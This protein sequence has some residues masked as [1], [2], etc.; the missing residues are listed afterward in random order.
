MKGKFKMKDLQ[1][2]PLKPE[3]AKDDELRQLRAE[4]DEK[5]LLIQRMENT[6]SWKVTKPLRMLRNLKIFECHW[7]Y[8][9]ASWKGKLLRFCAKTF[10][11]KRLILQSGL[12]DQEYYLK[13]NPDVAQGGVDPLRHF[14]RHGGFEGRK[15]N[16]FFDAAYYLQYNQDVNHKRIHPLIHYILYGEQEGRK[17]CAEFDPMYYLDTYSDVH[18]VGVSPLT[19]YLHYGQKEGRLTHAVVEE[20]NTDTY[21]Y[22][23]QKVRERLKIIPH[24][25]NHYTFIDLK[26]DVKSKKVG[27]HLHLFYVDMAD[28]FID[29]L[30]NISVKFTLFVS[31]TNKDDVE[32]ITKNFKEKVNNLEHIEVE[33][34]ENRGRDIA[35]LIITF[36][37]K[38][39]GF[40]YI[41]HVHTK[42]SPHYG[43]NNWGEHIINTL[44]G[45]QSI[46]N[47]N[48]NIL[49]ENG[50]IIFNEPNF[51]I[52]LYN[53]GWSGDKIFAKE[54]LEKYSHFD[55]NDFPAI[56]FPQGSMFWA[57]IDA[58][59]EFL[60]LPLSYKDFPTE[61][62][63]QDG[64]IAHA[65]E[66][67]MLI[68][69]SKCPGKAYCIYSDNNPE[70]FGYYE[71]QEDFSNY[72]RRYSYI[73]ILSYYL[74]QF[75]TNPVNDAWHG[76]GFTEWTKVAAAN[77]LFYTHY[78][79]HIPHKDLGYYH[80][81]TPDILKKQAEMMKK[82]G[83]YGQIFY[84]YWFT[85]RLILEKPAQILLD[86]KDI[87]MPFCFCW[88]NEN[89]TKKW[90]GSESETILEQ[91]YSQKDAAYFIRYL[92]PFF[93]DHRYI[94][95][96]LRPVL[97]IYRP[98]SFSNFLEYK[99]VWENECK[100]AGIPMPYLVS[101][102]TINVVSPQEYGMDAAVE[103]V[104]YDWT[105]G[106]CPEKK[107]KLTFFNTFNGTVL[108]YNDVA[109]Y[110]E[111]MD[112][113]KEFTWFRSVVPM[114]D[115][116]ARYNENA[117]IVHNS[118]PVRFQKWLNNIVEYTVKNL[119]NDKQFVIVNAWNEWAEGDHL[120]P[121]CK[122]GY[123]YLNSIGR[124]LS[125]NYRHEY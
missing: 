83:V 40:D 50:K 64:T 20:L 125:S 113:K 60:T 69:T 12:F 26:E 73:K 63:P 118:T 16:P 48:L 25:H 22:N 55:I 114:W 17:P 81:T 53:F 84:H 47:Q 87:D 5:N 67:I 121:D 71:E 109:K 124:V 122:Y 86:N 94:K 74:P 43:K 70:G 42:K 23:L 6:F 32:D 52:P 56:D 108:D 99:E 45:N 51:I 98:S 37:K 96:D 34:V 117:Y 111:D 27:I 41:C 33:V 24:F 102:L 13:H 54:L 93:K 106:N 18:E 29:K 39:L 75:D 28:Y 8:Q 112:V 4:L 95:I 1:Q 89:W 105:A 78:Q 58:M 46:V 91:T 31:T 123:A 9:D 76:K 62:L 116:T 97:Y 61:P 57:K 90:D 59:K 65:L 101:V 92:I 38:L 80:L 11:P 88:A 68:F 82:S 107:E 44:L 119:P 103:R 120:E 49:N 35:P 100:K 110:Y 7:S 21:E 66:R 36:G 85:G 79:Q 10:W 3:H 15:P 2:Q 19:H 14:L 30:N 72:E 104:L 77:P 115:N